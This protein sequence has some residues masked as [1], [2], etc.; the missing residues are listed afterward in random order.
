MP[1]LLFEIWSYLLYS[2]ALN[3]SYSDLCLLN[4]WNYRHVPPCWALP[5]PNSM[6]VCIVAPESIR[7]YCLTPENSFNMGEHRLS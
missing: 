6:Y 5:V 1:S 3:Y 4:K 7:F 2:M